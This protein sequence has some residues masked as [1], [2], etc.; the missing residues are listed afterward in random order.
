MAEHTH[1]LTT[2]LSAETIWD[3]VRDMDG[4][5]PFVLGYQGHEQRDERESRWTLKADLGNM[6]RSV[7]FRVV[8]TE[9]V[10]PERVRFTL[11]GIGEDMRGEG[12]FRI[13]KLEGSATAPETPEAAAPG[14][15]LRLWSAIA[16][17]LLGHG[18]GGKRRARGTPGK[19]PVVRLT[20][21][22]SMTPGGAMAPMLDAMIKPVM[23]ATA[24]HLAQQIVVHLETREAPS[25]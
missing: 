12:L 17:R 25:L 24:E 1:A 7:D 15:L 4:W 23:V 16:R 9:W 13:E 11:E 21:R 18:R 3:F 22:M 8:I 5:A 20:F 19:P 6:T 14:L 10:E 2:H